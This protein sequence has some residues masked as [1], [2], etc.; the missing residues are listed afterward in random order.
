MPDIQKVMDLID[1]HSDFLIA[2]NAEYSY[3][4]LIGQDQ[5]E[6]VFY[7]LKKHE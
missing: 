7:I 5:I 3:K 1:F 2:K 6:L 4:I